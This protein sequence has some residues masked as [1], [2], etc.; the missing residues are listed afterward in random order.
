MD[1]IIGH[2]DADGW[3]GPQRSGPR[4]AGR[5]VRRLAADG[6][7]QGTA[8]V[9]RRRRRRADHHGGGEAV[10]AHHEVMQEWPLHDWGRV[11]WADLVH[12]LDLLYER[13]GDTSLLDTA[14]LA[15][16]Q[17]LRLGCVRRGIPVTGTKV[18]DEMLQTIPGP[19]PTA[20][21]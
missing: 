11:R 6:P 13:T 15:H 4:R 12:C 14:R 19:R 20:P 18:T 3:M 17:G 7:A 10:P 8:A 5:P 9:S 2:Q 1:Y 21:G 16:E